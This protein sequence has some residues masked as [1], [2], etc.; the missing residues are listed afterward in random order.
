MG[1]STVDG[2]QTWV[3]AH[4]VL[5]AKGTPATVGARYPVASVTKLFTA[6]VVMQLVEAGQ[7]RLD[8]LLVELL[9][10]EVTKGLHVL[11]GKDLTGSITVEHLL[12]HTSGLPD[13]YE[14]AAKGAVSPQKRLLRG[15]DAPVPF[16]EVIR[17]VRDDLKP[18][19]P[20]Q[21]DRGRRKARYS[22]TN[23]QLLG[24]I[25]EEIT[26]MPVHQVFAD[27]IFSPLDLR[28]TSSY[29]HL[30]ASGEGPGPDAEVWARGKV[31][32]VDGAL[33]HQKADGGVIS[34]LTDQMTFMRAL[35]A[36]D[37]F[38]DP[39]TWSRMRER[40]ARVFFPVEYGLGVMRYAPSRLM[41]PMFPVPPLYGH[42]G[43][44]A[45]WL[46]HCPDLGVVTAG[47][48][49]VG[50]P[51]LPYRFLPRALKIISS[52]INEN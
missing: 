43:S 44:T 37:L 13:Y 9:P 19:F 24:A 50:Q 2:S 21:P 26:G 27:R 16:E 38:E 23:Y 41:S 35:V 34:N 45:T 51:P 5:D 15:E 52:G 14:E 17:L 11:E 3:G 6:V 33:T 12:G 28:S 32:K 29:P 25:I 18:H 10:V 39:A 48:F 36:G 49:D 46:F 8:S 30:P 42:T 47:A 40:F 4:G 1:V 22:D 7:V 31:L 20:P